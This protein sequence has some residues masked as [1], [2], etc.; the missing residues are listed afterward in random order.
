M[1]KIIFSLFLVMVTLCIDNVEAKNYSMIGTETTNGWYLVKSLN[2]E[3]DYNWAYYEDGVEKKRY[4]QILAA[5]MGWA[6]APSNSLEAFKLTKTNE[7]YGNETDIR[8]TKDN[9]P[10][11]IHNTAINSYARNM[12]KSVISETKNVSDLTLEQIKQYNF[13]IRGG[14]V[15]DNYQGNKIT[16]LEEALSWASENNMLFALELKEGTREQIESVV[17]LV[18][19]YNMQDR[20]VYYSFEESLLGYVKDYYDHGY[21]RLLDKSQYPNTYPNV[22]KLT[23]EELTEI[24]N[25]LKT[26]NNLVYLCG[27]Y[28]ESQKLNAPDLPNDLYKSMSK[29]ELPVLVEEQEEIK[30]ETSNKSENQTEIKVPSTGVTI[31]FYLKIIGVLIILS[32]VLILI[33]SQNKRTS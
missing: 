21:L 16:T 23:N 5:H 30:E 7:F 13:L 10:V 9:V 14:K 24:Y 17:K 2:K 31:P 15:L 3:N 18:K 29:Y 12:D 4:S 11:L 25:S 27:S 28:G 8:F 1:R 20:V 26:N 19:Q 6:G 22:Q 32:G 33:K